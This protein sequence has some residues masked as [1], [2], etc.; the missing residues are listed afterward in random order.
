MN[1]KQVAGEIEILACEF[2][3]REFQLDRVACDGPRLNWLFRARPPDYNRFL[4][5]N[6]E[7]E[8]LDGRKRSVRFVTVPGA[9]K[10]ETGLSGYG[11]SRETERC[12]CQQEPR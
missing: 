11:I 3:G 5:I 12:T 2:A 1:Q 7:G 4:T 6:L 8:C 10:I 9:D